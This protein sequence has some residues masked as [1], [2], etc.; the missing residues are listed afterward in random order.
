MERRAALPWEQ[1]NWLD[2]AAAWTEGRLLRLGI[3]PRGQLTLHRVRPWAAVASIDTSEGRLWFKEPAPAMAFEAAL[4]ALVS[5]R[6]PDDCPEVVAWEGSRLLTR[7]AGPLLRTLLETDPAAAPRW[8]DI[9]PRYAEVQLAHTGDVDRLLGLGVPDK[10]PQALLSDYPRLVREVRGLDAVPVD[11]ARLAALASALER[12]LAALDGPVPMTVVH[13][14]VH[15]ANVF[16]LNGHARF[17][18]WGEGVVSHPFAGLTNTLRD[19]TYRSGLEPGS[20]EVVRLRD[21]YLEPWTRLAPL[22]DLRPMFAAGYLLGML[23]RAATWERFL[24]TASD[25]VRAEYDRNAAIWLDIL[26]DALEEG[27]RLGAS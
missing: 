16:V 2:A 5:A 27:V 22:H 8:E 19:I 6:S 24:A 11:R 14:E 4:T 25:D 13:E 9:L 3:E 12:A 26:R 21:T 15:E 7:D 17:M 18:D 1:A 23:C 10:R 20:R